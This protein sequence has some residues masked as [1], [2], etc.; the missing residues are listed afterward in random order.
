M[1][2]Y[3][4]A[5]ASRPPLCT[6]QEAIRKGNFITW[7]GTEEINFV[8]FIQDTTAIDKGHLDQERQN[9]QSTRQIVTDLDAFP[10]DG[11]GKKTHEYASIVLPLDPQLKAYLDITGRFH[12]KLTRGNEYLYVCYAFD[13]NII[14]AEPIPSR[15]ARTLVT[16]WEKIMLKLLNM[17]IQQNI[18]FWTMK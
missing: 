9:L 1:A 15:Q 13:G 7:P 8:K 11:I 12:H 2:T 18:S 3:L 5:Y 14:L 6:F 10:T 4:H 17:V 16:A